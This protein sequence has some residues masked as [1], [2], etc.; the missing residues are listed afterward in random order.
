MSGKARLPLLR[1]RPLQL[2]KQQSQR[3]DIKAHLHLNH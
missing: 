1:R 2:G 3:T